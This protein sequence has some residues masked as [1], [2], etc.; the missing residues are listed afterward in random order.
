MGGSQPYLYEQPARYSA[1]D[2][3]NGFNPKAATMASRAPPPRP[4]PKQEGPLVNFNRHPDSYLI[5]PY[6]Q[7][8]VKPLNP[9]TKNGIKWTRWVQLAFRILQLVGA[10]GMLICVICIKGTQDAEGWILRIP[11]GIDL[12][13]TLYAIYHLMRPAKGRTPASSAS[14]HFFALFMDTGMIPF[15]VFI[16]MMANSKYGQA[17][18]T[19]QRW[20]S[21]FSSESAT[22]KLLLATWL[23][24]V[25]QGSLHLISIFLDLYLVV[26]FRRIARLPPDMNPLEDNLTR[27]ASKHKHKNSEITM[28]SNMSEKRVSDL[29]GSTLSLNAPSRLSQA[30]EPLI[31]DT[32][33]MSFFHSRT[34]SSS[35]FSP[36]NPETARLSRKHLPEQ[37]YQE[38]LSARTSRTDL[39][40][41]ER[42]RS[43]GPAPSHHSRSHS[44]V[45]EV[46]SRSRSRSRGSPSQRAS[47]F[48]EPTAADIASMPN[49]SRS[50]RVPSPQQATDVQSK[51]GSFVSGPSPQ[52]GSYHEKL[53]PELKSM[54][55]HEK[56]TS[57][58]DDN[59]FV[60]AS[61]SGSDASNSEHDP[62]NYEKPQTRSYQHLPRYAQ[63][64]Q[65]NT[66]TQHQ[67]QQ[68][69][70]FL[71]H[72]PYAP[73]P[74]GRAL[75]T[76]SHHSTS[77]TRPGT[78]TRTGTKGRYYGDLKAAT[79]GIL[80]QP[81]TNAP[82]VRSVK[83]VKSQC[84]YAGAPEY[85]SGYAY[86]NGNGMGD[87]P[88]VVS[89]TGVDLDD[90]GIWGARCWDDGMLAGRLLRRGEGVGE[91]GLVQRK[92][93]GVA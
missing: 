72:D 42:S 7:T 61:P 45:D 78:L 29:T 32:R 26:V 81:S 15:Y 68:Q 66:P 16:A 37:V 62:F 35:T 90:G 36:H 46:R 70:A 30:A 69:H 71:S 56:K 25:T 47:A 3:Y 39:H 33:A 79:Q 40:S 63:S 55:S 52:P 31:P 76:S 12:L 74:I 83:S 19:D 34:D 77:S 82:S 9:N 14:Y 27:R 84:E 65:T 17:P 73:S 5:L 24:A 49:S 6:G 2:P 18:G 75:T 38:H 48:L 91:E 44:R 43:R 92:V 89:R 67:Q 64:P 86:G 28:H 4:R 23:T 87:S 88:R 13:I 93:S 54:P 80:R 60:H 59:W 21:F 51:R 10:I 58:T 22:G 57:L 53:L 50:S 8:N 11:P 1:I 41:R 85:G 20:T